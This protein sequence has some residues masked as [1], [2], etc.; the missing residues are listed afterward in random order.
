MS[1]HATPAASPPRASRRACSRGWGTATMIGCSRARPSRMNG[2]TMST[3]SVS[4]RY[5]QHSCRYVRCAR[6]NRP[7]SAVTVPAGPA[8]PCPDR[9][10]RAEPPPGPLAGPGDRAGPIRG[11]G[12]DQGQPAAF[13]TCR[14]WV[15][16]TTRSM[17]AIDGRATPWSAA[18]CASTRSSTA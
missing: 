1:A 12:G 15:A 16:I 4:P 8:A 9:P 11:L 18:A 10:G 2:T 7:V 5:S 13:R 14:G 3:N 17:N 6:A